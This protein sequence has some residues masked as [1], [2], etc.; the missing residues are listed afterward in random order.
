M[1]QYIINIYNNEIEDYSHEEII[2]DGDLYEA[3]SKG[4]ELAKEA[5]LTDCGIAIYQSQDYYDGEDCII[6]FELYDE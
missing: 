6:F 3:I 5:N 1:E 4:K 2:L